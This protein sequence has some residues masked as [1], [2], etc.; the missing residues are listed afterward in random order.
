MNTTDQLIDPD[1]PEFGSRFDTNRD[2]FTIYQASCRWTGV[3]PAEDGMFRD[4]QERLI[5]LTLGGV[6]SDPYHVNRSV[7]AALLA[8]VK[9]GEFH[10]VPMLNKQGDI[11]DSTVLSRK[12]LLEWAKKHGETPAFLFATIGR[13]VA[14][15]AT[16]SASAKKADAK[17]NGNWKNQIQAAA[18]EHWIT[19]RASGANPTV[20]S[21]LDRMANWCSQND[22]KTDGGIHPSSGYLRT[23]VLGGKHWTP[24][25]HSVEQA[26]RHVEQAAQ[27]AQA[28]VAQV[29]Q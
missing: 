29:S 24:P 23:H 25:K 19:L 5:R 14:L 18:Y 15:V 21:I 28:E 3:E 27:V 17:P 10:T 7:R 1:F 16:V 4:E 9:H 13:Q 6:K 12:E 8:S 22:V 11:D 20:H 26:K 2:R